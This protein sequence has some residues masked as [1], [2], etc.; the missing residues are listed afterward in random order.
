MA[1]S[2]S[3]SVLHPL[4]VLITKPLQLQKPRLS[5]PCIR[6][7]V[8]RTGTLLSMPLYRSPQDRQEAH[9]LLPRQTARPKHTA[10][11]GEW[12]HPSLC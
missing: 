3:I 7:V 4:Q 1:V 8:L 11:E 10:A 5:L 2:V 6:S 12:V 9:A